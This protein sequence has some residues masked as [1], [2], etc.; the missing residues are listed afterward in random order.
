ML[1]ALRARNWP[2]AQT[3]AGDAL[4]QKLVT[5]IRLLMP[6]QATPQEILD[7]LQ[8][9][10][11]WPDRPVL[12][13]RY[14]DA[15]ASDPDEPAVAT[16]CKSHAP[17]DPKA[18]LRCAEAYAATNDAPRAT[19]AARKAWVE[20]LAQP[21]EEAAFLARWG[22]TPTEEDQHHRFDHLAPTN[23]AAAQRQLARLDPDYAHLGA[24]RLAFRHQDANALS[25]L[26]AVPESLRADPAL[27]LEEARFLRRTHAESA[28][29]ALW[30]GAASEAEAHL[31]PA[32]RRVPFWSERDTLA[33]ELLQDHQPQDAYAVAND[34]SQSTDQSLEA[35]FLAG[36]IALTALHDPSLARA[37]FQALSAHSQSAITQSRAKY[38][39]AHAAPDA[40]GTKTYLQQAAAWPLTYYGQKAAIEAGEAEPALHALIASLR[41]PAVPPAEAAQI[42]ASDLFRAAGILVS[43]QDPKRAADFYQCLIQPPAT[44]AQRTLVAQAAL[45]DGMPD[46]AVLAARLAGRYGAAI[47][48]SGWPIPRTGLSLQPP[49]GPVPPALVLAIMR[50]ESSFDP[51]IISPAGAYGLMQLMPQTAAQLAR[52]DHIQAGPLSDPTINMRLGTLYLAGLID[53]FAL[54]PVAIAAYNAGPHRVQQWLDAAAP[55]A[56]DSDAMTDWIES[57][58]F[59]ETRNYVQRVLEN[60][61]IYEARLKK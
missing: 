25:F 60:E 22:K 43:W 7:F 17:Q 32:S 28:A 29:A 51:K 16:L 23:Q 19:A 3:L 56:D 54:V 21:E 9:N 41:D 4:G 33:R 38:W 58:P 34:T 6:D 55:T 59:A 49:P 20:G 57:I 13:Q 26:A 5:F 11:T 15:L 40:A 47:P 27:L 39:L 45:R 37:H 10:P 30:H 44:L 18:L 61:T 12:E 48:Q 8:A 31:Q 36:W 35:D 1:Q 42:Q 24:A 52:A 14:G 46:I 53:R 2:A 50:Q